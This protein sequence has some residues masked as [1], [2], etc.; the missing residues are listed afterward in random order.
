MGGGGPENL[1]LTEYDQ[2]HDHDSNQPIGPSRK[3]RFRPTEWAELSMEGPAGYRGS[4]E[5]VG[6]EE[7][8][9]VGSPASGIFASWQQRRTLVEPSMPNA[10]KE[11]DPLEEG[12]VTE[13]NQTFY[14]M[15]QR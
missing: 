15:Q 12:Q 10:K 4:H 9:D 13:T 2:P 5:G 7:Q 6:T 14:D 8:G 1:N 11:S 3:V